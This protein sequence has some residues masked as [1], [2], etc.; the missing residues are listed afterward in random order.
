MRRIILKYSEE[1]AENLTKKL[2][3]PE[4]PKKLKAPLPLGL[5]FLG[6]R[7]PYY[8]GKTSFQIGIGFPTV[9]TLGALVQA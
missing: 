1:Q 4:G 9:I 3:K 8:R 2:A 6:K 7:K 5:S